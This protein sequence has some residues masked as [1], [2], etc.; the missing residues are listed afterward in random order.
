LG[1]VEHE[2]SGAMR[3]AATALVE[4]DV[5][6]HRPG[7]RE[8]IAA[9]VESQPNLPCAFGVDSARSVAVS[10]RCGRSLVIQ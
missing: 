1:A 5:A 10:G 7:V 3:A 8:E 6:R 2:L 4:L 9:L